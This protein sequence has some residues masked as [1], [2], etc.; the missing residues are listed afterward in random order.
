MHTFVLKKRTRC[1]LYNLISYNLCTWSVWGICNEQS[2]ISKIAN[3]V[4][5]EEM[6]QFSHNNWNQT[7][8]WTG[9]IFFSPGKF[10]IKNVV[11]R[12][13]FFYEKNQDNLDENFAVPGP[14][15]IL[16]SLW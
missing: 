5:R 12:A 10:I 1:P 15:S 9:N 14:N 7:L 16:L 8:F 13:D 4:M 2:G 6:F 11:L 3:F